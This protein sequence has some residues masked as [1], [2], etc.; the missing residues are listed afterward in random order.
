[1]NS[2]NIK[3]KSTIIDEHCAVISDNNCTYYIITI[4]DLFKVIDTFVLNTHISNIDDLK[5]S[6]INGVNNNLKTELRKIFDSDKDILDSY[7][8]YYIGNSYYD[9]IPNIESM[10]NL[11]DIDALFSILDEFKGDLSGL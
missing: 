9:S 6:I 1:M 4:D 2:Y 8:Y 3:I 7:E 10:L 5:N 11:I